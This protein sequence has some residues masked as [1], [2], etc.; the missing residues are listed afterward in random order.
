[1]GWCRGKRANKPGC[2]LDWSAVLASHLPTREMISK[3]WL[4]QGGRNQPIP[5]F[6]LSFSLCLCFSVSFYLSLFL[7]PLLL[8]LKLY[9]SLYYVSFLLQPFFLPFTSLSLCLSVYV[10]IYL[11]I[12]GIG[13]DTDIQSSVVWIIVFLAKAN[14]WFFFNLGLLVKNENI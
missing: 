8:S 4:I 7:C 12:I 1:M 2:S 9:L 6:F 14:L 5:S 10:I 3:T 13:S 11:R